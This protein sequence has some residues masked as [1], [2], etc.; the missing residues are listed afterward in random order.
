MPVLSPE[1]RSAANE[2]GLDASYASWLASLDA[3]P[4]PGSELPL[5]TSQDAEV[6][7]RTGVADSDAAAVLESQR[8]LDRSA[9]LR[10]LL[11][12]CRRLTIAHLGDPNAPELQLPQLPAALGL[13]GRCFPAHLFLAT[14]PLTI[15]WQQRQGVPAEPCWAVFADLGR[16]M[17]IYRS[18]YGTTGVEEPWWL[19]LHLRGLIYEF[20]RLQYN[21]LRIGAGLMSPQCWYDDAEAGR[22][23]AGFRP[24][25]DAVGVHIPET[26]PMTPQ[27]CADSLASARTFF[28]NYF[29]SPTRRLAI[30]ESWLL[31]GQLTEYLSSD[32]NIIQF[33]RLF[34]IA[35]GWRSGDKDVAQFIFQRGVEDLDEVPQ[36]TTLQRAIL[37]HLR[38]GRHWRLRCGWREL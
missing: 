27:A 18:A 36:Q 38:A 3:A 14:L 4:D 33:Q 9:G 8:L 35:P 1:G 20:G 25:D 37:S 17:D 19:L 5:C 10:W 26:G 31:D 22:L 32:T 15:D 29:P 11:R 24:C 2:L 16:Q 23:G 28:G 30:C 34:E 6:L 13:P 21:M 7:A 12:Q